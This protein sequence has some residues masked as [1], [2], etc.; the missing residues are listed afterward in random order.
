V[1]GALPAGALKRSGVRPRESPE[2]PARLRDEEPLADRIE[3]FDGC[4][5]DTGPCS[6]VGRTKALREQFE[7][8]GGASFCSS[9]WHVAL[10]EIALIFVLYR[11]HGLQLPSGGLAQ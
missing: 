1:G 5:F 2:L 3:L 7:D 11:V 9:L 8:Q 6:F 4:L 10:G